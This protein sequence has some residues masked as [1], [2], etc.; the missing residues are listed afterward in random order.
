MSQSI[1]ELGSGLDAL[2]FRMKA[3]WMSGDFDKIAQLYEPGAVAFIKRL[4][5]TPGT[6]LLDV[7]CGSGNL[8]I[9]AARLGAA[10]SGIDIA[11]NLLETA[12]TRA[13]NEGLV[14]MF[15]EGDAEQ[16]PYRDG[17]FDV[18]VSKLDRE[19]SDRIGDAAVNRC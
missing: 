10:V 14:I 5:L 16:M 8:A 9:P 15:D 11:P 13:L 2:K 1:A 7:A 4:S 17:S 19:F 6:R 12:E 18:V 3:T